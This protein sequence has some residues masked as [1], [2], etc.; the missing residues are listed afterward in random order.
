MRMTVREYENEC[1]KAYEND[2]M[3]EYDNDCRKAYENDCM[4]KQRI[5]VGERMRMTV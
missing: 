3:R 4:R 5:I 1:R 2:C